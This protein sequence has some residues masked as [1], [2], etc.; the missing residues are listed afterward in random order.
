MQSL[1]NPKNDRVVDSVKPPPNKPL[2]S[3]LIW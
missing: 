3:E 2:S 1:P